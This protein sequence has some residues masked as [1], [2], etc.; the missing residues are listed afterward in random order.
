[1]EWELF[2]RVLEEWELKCPNCRKTWIAEIFWGYPGDIDSVEEELSKKEIVL[3]GCLITDND[4]RWEC[5]NCHHRW[6][7]AEHNDDKTDSFDF[8]KGFNIEEVYDQ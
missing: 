7:F 5:N 8:D 1:M 3:G 4:P 6:G 2:T